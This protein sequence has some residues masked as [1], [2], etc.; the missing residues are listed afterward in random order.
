M[1]T[2]ATSVWGRSYAGSSPMR[3][4]FAEVEAEIRQWGESDDRISE[5]NALIAALPEAQIAEEA[6]AR[7]EIAR[8]K[9]AE[10]PYVVLYRKARKDGS[11]FKGRRRFKTDAEQARFIREAPGDVAVTFYTT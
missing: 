10:R 11:V 5:R 6:E 3:S 1:S 9:A 4:R 8:R 2:K 7:A